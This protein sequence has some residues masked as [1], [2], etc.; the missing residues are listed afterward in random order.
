MTDTRNRKR[1]LKFAELSLLIGLLAALAWGM[2]ALRS[3]RALSDK[4]VRLHI[5]AN[6]DSDADQ[7]L[8]LQVRDAVL[9]RAEEL[10]RE[11]D[12]AMYTEKKQ[13]KGSRENK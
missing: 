10:L 6:S 11:A 8:K 5:L 12:D 7:A 9:V 4:V 3:Q 13:M 2:W 1:F